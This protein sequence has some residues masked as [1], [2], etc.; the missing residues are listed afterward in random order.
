MMDSKIIFESAERT[1]KWLLANQATDRLDANKGRFP[2]IRHPGGAGDPPFPTSQSWD[3]GCSLM[4]LL[5]MYKRTG[6]QKYLNAA[7]LAGRYILSLQMTDPRKKL[8][9]GVY[10]EVTP[11]SME[12]CP[13]DSASAALALTWLYEATKN[14]EYLDSAVL[15]ADWLMEYGMFDGWVRWAVLMDGQD[16]LYAKGSFQSGCALMFHDLFMQTRDLRYIERGMRPI[17]DLYIRDFLREDGS[18]I[19]RR[20]IMSNRLFEFDSEQP[21]QVEFTMHD[22]NDDFGCAALMRAAE[23]FDD[24]KYDEAALRFTRWLAHHQDPDGDFGNGS[25][26]SAIP[27]ALIYFHDLGEKYHD[28]ELLAARDRTLETL[29]QFQF[30]NSADPCIDGGFPAEGHKGEMVCGLRMTQYALAALLHVES[31]LKEVWLGRCNRKFR[32]PLHDLKTNPLKFK[33]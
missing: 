19:G 26:P 24:P 17:V 3:T 16:H 13:R 33:W 18:L 15:Y 6:K 27:M 2:T 14:P 32:D 8:Y 28:Q 4:G 1:A 30:K 7:E 12:L 10:R 25:A 5:A 23:I 31:D 9:Y 21:D 20:E 11:Q 22:F 29:L